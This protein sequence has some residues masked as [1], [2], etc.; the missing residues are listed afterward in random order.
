MHPTVIPASSHAATTP[1][2]PAQADSVHDIHAIAWRIAASLHRRIDHCC[3]DVAE[4][5]AEALLGWAEAAPLYV[6][7]RGATRLSHA[8]PRMYGRPRDRVRSEFRLRRVQRAW[9]A[10]E[11]AGS[12]EAS[13]STRLAVR[14]AVQRALPTLGT[15]ERL[16]LEQGYFGGSSLREIAESAHLSSDALQRAHQ[17]L[18]QRLRDAMAADTTTVAA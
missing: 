11:T 5:Q 16:V 15:A 10:T 18:L 9:D 2:P 3:L 12:C 4:L 7:E 13:P 6:P 14:Q 8:W 1:C 17:R